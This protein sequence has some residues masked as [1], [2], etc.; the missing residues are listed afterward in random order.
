M[1]TPTK[2]LTDGTGRIEITVSDK[3]DNFVRT[4]DKKKDKII[5][6]TYKEWCQKVAENINLGK[7]PAYHEAEVITDKENI[8]N[9]M[10]VGL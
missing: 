8:N 6:M 2:R 5:N 9:C 4:Y 10:V 1:S 3:K 7:V